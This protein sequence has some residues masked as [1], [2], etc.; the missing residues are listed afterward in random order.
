M[1]GLNSCNHKFDERRVPISASAAGHKTQ[2]FENIPDNCPIVFGYWLVVGIVLALLYVTLGQYNLPDWL[3]M[4]IYVT[5]EMLAPV[6]LLAAT[7][8]I[9]ASITKIIVGGI[10]TKRR[11]Q[12]ENVRQG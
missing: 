7:A 9:V 10:K 6:V 8:C 3:G 5:A 4:T 1:N 2:G 12:E 11:R